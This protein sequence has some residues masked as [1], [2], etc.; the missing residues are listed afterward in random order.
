[1]K[2]LDKSTL[3][4]IASEFLS[5]GEKV[6]AIRYV[7]EVT[8]ASLSEAKDMVD[9]MC[10]EYEKR[11]TLSGLYSYD[12]DTVYGAVD[13]KAVEEQ[14]RR[15]FSK[16]TLIPAIKY[17]REATGVGLA[18][19]KNAVERI[20][21]ATYVPPQ[22][23][24]QQG[25]KPQA[26]QADPDRNWKIGTGLFFIILGLAMVGL[27]LYLFFMVPKRKAESIAKIVNA[28][29]VDHRDWLLE[30]GYTEYVTDGNYLGYDAW[31]DTTIDNKR[32][33]V[34][35]PD[36]AEDGYL[37]VLY[38]D[39]PKYPGE[40]CTGIAIYYNGET[41]QDTVEVRDGTVYENVT[42]VNSDDIE[43]YGVASWKPEVEVDKTR[44]KAMSMSIPLCI[45]GLYFA[46]SGV[47]TVK[48]NKKK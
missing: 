46:V 26:Q 44:K 13:V 37:G 45:G 27:A 48:R 29:S 19:A 30:N 8:G 11:G 9:K 6:A 24:N 34:Y 7:R 41:K 33:Y 4:Y 14:V 15:N 16:D 22:T 21:G 3:N 35:E 18:E 20:L 17:Y 42:V 39:K 10:E 38:A 28:I 5:T 25:G 23:P 2:E 36:S 12:E 47:I 1:M 32:L 40:F 31:Y 43:V